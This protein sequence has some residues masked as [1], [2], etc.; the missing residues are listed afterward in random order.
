MMKYMLKDSANE[1]I[2]IISKSFFLPIIVTL[3]KLG[4]NWAR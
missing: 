3:S 2:Y 4:Q 1:I